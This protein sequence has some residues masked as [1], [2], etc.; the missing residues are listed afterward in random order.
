[1]KI[2]AYFT[3]G[4]EDALA[5]L[6]AARFGDLKMDRGYIHG[7]FKGMVEINPTAKNIDEIAFKEG[8]LSVF[9]PQYLSTKLPNNP[10]FIGGR[11]FA[12]LAIFL[13]KSLLV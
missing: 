4:K 1:M 5:G 11:M 7:Y 6:N 10:S 3:Q 9:Y 2:N 12:D 8:Y 13:E